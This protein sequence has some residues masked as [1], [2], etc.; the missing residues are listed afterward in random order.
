M[1]IPYSKI[2]DLIGH[3]NSLPQDKWINASEVARTLQSLIDSDVA[4]LEALAQEFRDDF[5]SMA[6]I[7][8][9]TDY[10]EQ[11]DEVKQE[12]SRAREELAKKD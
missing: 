8:S 2:E 11:S 6:Y 7:Q 10:D 1:S 4:E 9:Y 3:Y 5:D 12:Y